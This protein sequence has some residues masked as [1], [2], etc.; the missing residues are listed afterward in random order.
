FGPEG[1]NTRQFFANTEFFADFGRYDVRLTVPR[2]WTVGATGQEVS[3][4]DTDG[5]TIHT[6]A[7]DRVHDFA[8]TTSPAFV[9]SVRVFQHDTLPDVRMRLLLQPEHAGQEDRHFAATAAALARYGEWYGPYPY[10]Q[11]A[12]VDPAWQSGSGGM[13]YPTLFTAGTR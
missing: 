5:G 2:G 10:P 11:I 4:A 3:R 9:E 6:Y 13:E 12:I 7:Q 8:W 1:W